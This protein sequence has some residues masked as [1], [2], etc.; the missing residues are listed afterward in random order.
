MGGVAAGLAEYFSVD[1]LL[2]RVAFLV[3]LAIGGVGV[4]A[5][6]VLLALVPLEGNPDEP[7]PPVTGTRRN[8]A[9]G[10]TVLVGVLL[11]I[12]S[13]S[14]GSGSTWLFGFG[15]GWSSAFSCGSWLRPR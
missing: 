12:A 14:G 4:L 7:A 13:V 8:L 1:P 5:Y 9:I 15:P 10:G 2:V 11:L 3:S 6:L